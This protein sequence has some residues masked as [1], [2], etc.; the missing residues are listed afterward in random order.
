MLCYLQI[1]WPWANKSVCISFWNCKGHR[2]SS[3]STMRVKIKWNI[4]RKHLHR[5]LSIKTDLLSIFLE[6]FWRTLESI[7]QNQWHLVFVRVC[8]IHAWILHLALLQICLISNRDII[9]PRPMF[10]PSLYS[11]V[12]WF[13]TWAALWT[14]WEVLT[15]ISMSISISRDKVIIC[16][17][18][19]QVIEISLIK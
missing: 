5:K 7:W 11:L 9:F 14:P 12:R 10:Q 3:L 2:N 4:Y 6:S 15:K 1:A 16:L 19:D 8:F 18:C 13:S 17:N